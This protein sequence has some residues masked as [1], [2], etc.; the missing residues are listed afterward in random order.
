MSVVRAD[1]RRRWAAVAGLVA[2]VVVPTAWLRTGGPASGDD[3]TSARELLRRTLD[4]RTVA[5][6][7]LG[8]S[9]GTLGLPTLP[10]LG[11]VAELLGG[12]TRSR[13]WWSG[14]DRW[15]VDVVT[16]TGER[17]TYG[18]P[19]GVVGWDYERRLLQTVVGEP[20]ARLPRAD[21]LL[22][23][24]A[25]RRLLA[26]VAPQDSV[27]RLPATRVGGRDAA[28]VR[29]RPADPGSTIGSA[30]VW[31]DVASGLPLRLRVVDR[32]GSESLVTQLTDVRLVRP[33]A[34]VTTP[35]QPAGVRDD[36][37]TA[38]DVAAAID[39]RAP[40]RLPDRLAG[41]PATRSVFEGSVQGSF[42]G[43]FHGSATYGR[44]LVRFAVLPLPDR[45]AGDVVANAR[46]AGAAEVDVPGGV[47]YRLGSTL[48]DAVVVQGDDGEHAYLLAGLV[49]SEVL[50]RAAR[51]LLSDP[52]P[53]RG[54]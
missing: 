11:A 26:G 52:P 31:V 27:R 15:R 18:T 12:T 17:G 3:G 44:G 32:A 7:A 21:D 47:E 34:A 42:H 28:G 30:E 54:P 38:P 35:P 14:P 50:T 51:Q 20:A 4:S 48:L 9:R 24:Q 10:R 22:A 40:W 33:S 13:V 41:L 53:R 39:Q 5:Y 8:E 6:T 49:T 43:S 16:A 37:V 29:V 23:P 46:S 1:A 19:D 25:A 45:L 2:L 36:V